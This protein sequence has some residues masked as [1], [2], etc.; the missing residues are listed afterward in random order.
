MK[1][2][3]YRLLIGTLVF[4]G[5]AIYFLNQG[6]NFSVTSHEEVLKIDVKIKQIVEK[7][8]KRKQT[9]HYVFYC[10]DFDNEFFI[11]PNYTKL[12]KKQSLEIHL[13]ENSNLTFKIGI[14]RSAKSALNTQ[15]RINV[16]S[17]ETP[18]D[19]YLNL[20]RVIK[21]NKGLRVFQL[22]VGVVFLIVGVFCFLKLKSY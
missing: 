10:Q 19:Y 17:I 12:F 13:N 20:N 18:N 15:Q 9:L 8:S 22:I 2:E 14:K 1:A 11:S 5:S 16:Y 21:K 3:K 6:V 7:P 4:F